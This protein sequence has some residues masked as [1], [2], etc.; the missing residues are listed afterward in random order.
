M[1]A[2]RKCEKDLLLRFH[3]VFDKKYAASHQDS[4]QEKVTPTQKKLNR[5]M[6]RSAGIANSEIGDKTSLAKLYC[7]N[8]LS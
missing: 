5:A 2:H 4:I 7:K 6:L 1:V 8:K 3:L